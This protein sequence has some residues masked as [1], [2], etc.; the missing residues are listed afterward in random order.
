MWWAT[1]W[2]RQTCEQG[3]ATGAWLAVFLPSL[4]MAA[5]TTF[6]VKARYPTAA[7]II[8]GAVVA[9]CSAA[10]SISVPESK[11]PCLDRSGRG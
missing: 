4:V 7:P 9:L 3:E 6:G 2:R 10:L 5:I 8:T 1:I 11:C